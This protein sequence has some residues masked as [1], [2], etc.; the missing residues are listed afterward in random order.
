MKKM[1]NIGCGYRFHLDWINLDFVKTGE[2]V[3]QHNILDGIPFGANSIDVIYN[4]HVLEHFQVN[5]AE[6]FLSECYR[7][8]KHGGVL[9]VVV[10]DLEQI[11]R[12]YL[13]HLREVQADD[14]AYNKAN[15]EW[16]MIE[17]YDQSVRTFSGGK[18][19]KYWSKADL[20][21]FNLVLERMGSEFISYRNNFPTDQKNIIP[22]TP[23]LNWAKFF[24]WGGLR[25]RLLRWLS[26]DRRVLE[27]IKLGRFRMGGEVHQWMY[28]SYSLGCLL[29]NVGFRNIRKV[30]AFTSCIPDWETHQWLDVDNGAIRK[31]DSLF[32]EAIK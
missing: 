31:P 2:A 18:M 22:E 24:R 6:F 25:N 14:N 15:Y 21:N 20:L 13:Q 16:S 7:V 29:S 27:Y 23:Q 3:I 8:L 17:L 9:R 10:P 12:L 4:S 26:G 1:L 32:M 28:D 11:V 30:N 5:E 19:A